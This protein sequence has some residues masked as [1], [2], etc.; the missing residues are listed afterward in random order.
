MNRIIAAAVLSLALIPA[1]AGD[2]RQPSAESFFGGIIQERDVTLAFDY[3]RDALKAAM[4]GR[5]ARPPEEL[6]QRAEAIGE[7]LK[8]RGAEA[9]RGAID[10][11]EEAVR[12]GMRD[13]NRPPLT[14]DQQR[15]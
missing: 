1:Y 7:E 11:L 8:R 13:S 4:A 6:T 5:E 3:L 15:T 10:A 2:A 14:N 9:A 12:D